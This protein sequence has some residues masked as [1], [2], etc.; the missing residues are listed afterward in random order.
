MAKGG[1]RE[2]CGRKTKFSAPADKTIRVPSA[3]AQKVM[4]VALVIDRYD[5]LDLPA[6]QVHEAIMREIEAVIREE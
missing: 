2:G 1:A 5:G 4:S 3:I 6:D